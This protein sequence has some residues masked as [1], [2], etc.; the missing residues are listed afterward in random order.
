MN[1]NY[2]YGVQSN[3]EERGLVNEDI[4]RVVTSA[5]ETGVKLLVDDGHILAKLRLE[6]FTVYVNYEI[7]G[8]Q[9]NIFDAYCHRV[10]LKEEV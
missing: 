8:D 5:E 3:N 9:V 1:F 4:E 2:E 6:N 7:N 10:T